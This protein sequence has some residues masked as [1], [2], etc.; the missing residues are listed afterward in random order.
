VLRLNAAEF[1]TLDVGGNDG[2]ALTSFANNHGCVVALSGATDFVADKTRIATIANG[3]ALMAR[4]T[5]MGCA[6]SALGAACL[7]VETDT[8]LASLAGL[9]IIGVAG[10]IAGE[11]AGGPGSFAVGIL[12]ALHRLDGATLIKRAKVA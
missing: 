11:K 1:A 2:T 5:A 7:A 10:E 8:W 6:A 12:D 3:H 9:L 4:I